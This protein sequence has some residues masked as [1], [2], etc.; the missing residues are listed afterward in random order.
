MSEVITTRKYV[1][2]K[3]VS[4]TIARLSITE[5]KWEVGEISHAVFGIVPLKALPGRFFQGDGSEQR[6]IRYARTVVD[7]TDAA[8]DAAGPG[9]VAIVNYSNEV[10]R[11][12]NPPPVES[13]VRTIIT[14]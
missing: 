10:Y 5:E 2:G 8:I 9:V 6:A 11:K 3:H 1:A 14:E 12:E 4:V 13:T 7:M